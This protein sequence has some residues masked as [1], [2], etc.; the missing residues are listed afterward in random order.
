MQEKLE[1]YRTLL[2]S[3]LLKLHQSQERLKRRQ[4][5]DL[6]REIKELRKH[7]ASLKDE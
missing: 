4:I 6:E 1:E 5:E 7:A 2:I 3:Q